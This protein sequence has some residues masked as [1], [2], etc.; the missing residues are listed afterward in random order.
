MFVALFLTSMIQESESFN[1]VNQV[2]YSLKFLHDVF[3]SKNPCKSSLVKLVL[4]SAKRKLSKPVQKKEV[5][6]P[7]HLKNLTTMLTKDGKRNLFNIR[8]L[9]MC[10]ISYAGFLRFNELVNIKRS[11]IHFR[12]AY[13]KLFIEKS[14]TD[15]YRDGSW[16]LIAKTGSLT[17][18]YNMI[19][20]YLKL[21]N[22]PKASEEFIFRGL[23]YFRKSKEHKLRKKNESLSY[24]RSREIVLKALS[25]IGLKREKFGLHSLRA[26]GATAA[27]D[28]GIED[29]LFKRHGR[30]RS[31]T[32]KDGYVKDNLKE[33]LSVSLS[34]GI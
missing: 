20:H 19:R 1:K 16:V 2:Y 28:A 15:L 22:I 23:T 18:P 17:C 21:A 13:L 29:R 32:A 10:L 7:I 4:E 27:A 24:T 5:I 3:G 26:G 30:W 33:L 6:K 12:K 11:D 31:E 9:T 25:E 14:K 34:L 8:T